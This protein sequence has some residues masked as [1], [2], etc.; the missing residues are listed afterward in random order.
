MKW[1]WNCRISIDSLWMVL[2]ILWL[3]VQ[4]THRKHI[5][6]DHSSPWNPKSIFT[7]GHLIY[8]DDFDFDLWLNSVFA[9]VDM[10]PQPV[11]M[12]R[13][14]AGAHTRRIVT[15][16]SEKLF[17]RCASWC[18]RSNIWRQT[19]FN[20]SFV[21]VFFFEACSMFS[22]DTSFL[23]FNYDIILWTDNK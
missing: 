10:A 2:L 17:S 5:K 3:G 1:A 20:D 16:P 15:W 11:V 23:E 22:L 6:R 8:V 12:H 4:W 7:Q 21:T 13:M 19:F 9:L 18:G 14:S